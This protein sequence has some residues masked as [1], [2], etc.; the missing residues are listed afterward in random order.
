[1]LNNAKLEDVIGKS[2]LKSYPVIYQNSVEILGGSNTNSTSENILKY[3]KEAFTQAIFNTYDFSFNVL[4][5]L[6]ESKIHCQLE[7]CI[8]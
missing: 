8:V 2:N 3:S 7:H 1:M 4:Y 6:L 5:V